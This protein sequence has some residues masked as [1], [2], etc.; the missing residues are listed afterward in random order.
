MRVE[1]EAELVTQEVQEQERQEGQDIGIEKEQEVLQT[2]ATTES[3]NSPRMHDFFSDWK[4]IE[5]RAKEFKKKRGEEIRERKKKK[6]D[7]KKDAHKKKEKGGKRSILTSTPQEKE[8]EQ[9]GEADVESEARADVENE[10]RRGEKGR[11]RRCGRCEACNRKCK[12]CDDGGKC[13][14]RIRNKGCVGRPDCK[15]PRP[16]RR[17]PIGTPGAVSQ[18]LI[19]KFQESE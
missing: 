1:E 10:D 19:G 12:T 3:S 7:T 4:M 9:G 18:T 6:E 13:G 17:R 5:K 15:K 14:Q 2:P 8:V 16:P 11:D